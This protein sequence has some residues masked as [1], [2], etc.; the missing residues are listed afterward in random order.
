MHGEHTVENFRGNEVV[1][2]TH[3]LN[4]NDEGLDSTDREK[5]QSRENIENSQPLV[6]DRGQPLMKLVDPRPGFY[7]GGN[8]DRVRGHRYFPERSSAAFPCNS[9]PHPG[10]RRSASWRAS[11]R[12]GLF[13]WGPGSKDGDCRECF[14]RRL[15]QSWRGAS[16]A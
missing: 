13:H 14:L 6:I 7:L 3:E 4:A 8:G 2:G 16:D 12:W 11:A 10:P 15:Q 9:R 1:V 5:Q